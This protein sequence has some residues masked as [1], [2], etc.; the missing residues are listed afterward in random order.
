M[1]GGQ[2]EESAL[3]IAELPGV[4]APPKPVLY[5][6]AAVIGCFA[7]G[8]LWLGYTGVQPDRLPPDQN[9][10]FPSIAATAAKAVPL[11]SLTPETPAETPV[12]KPPSKPSKAAE[13]SAT[14]A[15]DDQ[16]DTADQGDAAPEKAEG[17]PQK[18][19]R[20]APEPDDNHAID[21]LP[22]SSD[23]PHQDR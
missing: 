1:I 8:G 3:Q 12:A 2:P 19:A 20:L 6:A 4:P 23:A 14:N 15:A 17:K 9:G 7:L 5:L 10:A 21:D 13:K 18:P 16:D 22:V 11:S